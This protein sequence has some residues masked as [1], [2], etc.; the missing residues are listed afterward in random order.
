MSNKRIFYMVMTSVL[1]LMVAALGVTAQSG[2]NNIFS[3]ALDSGSPRPD[4]PSDSDASYIGPHEVVI[5]ERYQP[6]LQS[7]TAA[8]PVY[9]FYFTPQDEDGSVTVMFLYNTSDVTGTAT[10]ETYSLSGSPIISTT[11]NVPPRHLVRVASDTV[12]SIA[13]SW[14]DAVLVNFRTFSAYAKLGLSE[15]MKAE[16]YVAW[17]GGT[18]YDPL[19]AVPTLNLQLRSDRYWIFLPATQR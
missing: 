19:E 2:D 7:E 8:L 14:E 6:R 11:L 4:G 15:G 3:G 5:P 9:T 1:L 12:K 16:A 10:I 18:T 13:G 17:N